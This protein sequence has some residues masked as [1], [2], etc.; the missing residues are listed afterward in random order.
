MSVI[1]VKKTCLMLCTVN[2]FTLFCCKYGAS[3]LT[4]IVNNLTALNV[5]LVL[6]I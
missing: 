5:I 1:A 6:V 3:D 4:L 2:L